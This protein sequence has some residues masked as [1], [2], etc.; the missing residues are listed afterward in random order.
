MAIPK[1]P[2]EQLAEAFDPVSKPDGGKVKLIENDHDK[3]AFVH[4]HAHEHTEY[5][6][7]KDKKYTHTH[8]H[9]HSHEYHNDHKDDFNHPSK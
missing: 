6:D 2:S 1:P 4:N 8:E 5:K 9:T 3:Q 7:G